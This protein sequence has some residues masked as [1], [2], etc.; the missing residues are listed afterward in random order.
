ML[1]QTKKQCKVFPTLK[2]P[3]FPSIHTEEAWTRDVER[4]AHHCRAPIEE[5]EFYD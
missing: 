5:Q 3:C 2:W 1:I 4:Y